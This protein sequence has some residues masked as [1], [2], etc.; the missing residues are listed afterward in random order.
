MQFKVQTLLLDVYL[1]A[2]H[3]NWQCF[4]CFFWYQ[5]LSCF[6]YVLMDGSP[7]TCTLPK[8][9]GWKMNFPFW[10]FCLFSGTFAVSFTEWKWLFIIK[11]CFCWDVEP[12]NSCR[13]WL[14]HGICGDRLNI[15]T[16]EFICW[17]CVI[18]SNKYLEGFL[19]PIGIH[20]HE[21]LMFMVNDGYMQV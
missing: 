8:M 14:N 5:E 6:W 16:F 15:S 20:R 21:W 2:L 12:W 11:W 7:W 1:T 4:P 9:D 17:I 13:D 3:V 19:F 18:P 10:A